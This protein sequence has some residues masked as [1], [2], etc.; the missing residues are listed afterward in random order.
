MRNGVLSNTLLLT[1]LLLFG[2]L[3]ATK[4]ADIWGSYTPQ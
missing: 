2:L 4:L 1:S 3:L